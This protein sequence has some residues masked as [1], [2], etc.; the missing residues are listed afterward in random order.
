MASLYE[1]IV[2]LAGIILVLAVFVAAT[3]LGGL[4]SL[5][6]TVFLV[7]IGIKAILEL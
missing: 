5:L 3:M 4:L 6:G 7:V 2:A 1:G